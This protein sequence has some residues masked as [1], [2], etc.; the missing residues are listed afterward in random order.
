[1]NAIAR[2]LCWGGALI[3]LAAANFAGLI[4]DPAANTL[5]AIIPALWVATGGARNCLPR[6]AAA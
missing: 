5:F 1:M 4:A 2:G 6:K 3:A